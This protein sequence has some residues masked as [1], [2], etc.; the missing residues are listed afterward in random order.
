M[1]GGLVLLFIDRHRL[2]LVGAAMILVALLLAEITHA[3]IQRRAAGVRAG[4]GPLALQG[5]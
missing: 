4:I 2:S 1:L 3:C 5:L